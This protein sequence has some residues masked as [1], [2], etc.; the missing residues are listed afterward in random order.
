MKRKLLYAAAAALI[1]VIGVAGASLSYLSRWGE[2]TFKT[3]V[4]TTILFEPGQSVSQLA[5]HM[6][7]LKSGRFEQIGQSWVKHGFCAL[8]DVVCGRCD[9]ACPGVRATWPFDS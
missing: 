8:Q 5:Q 9:P 2:Q 6:Y 4:P 3:S 7:R 1:L